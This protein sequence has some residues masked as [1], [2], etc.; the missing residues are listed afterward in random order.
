[1]LNKIHNCINACSS[2]VFNA[3]LSNRPVSS[4]KSA[5]ITCVIKQYKARTSSVGVINSHESA[6]S[7]KKP[8]THTLSI[9]SV[10]GEAKNAQRA[11]NR[12][13]SSPS[14][15][16]LEAARRATGAATPY[17]AQLLRNSQ[18]PRSARARA[19]AESR[20]LLAFTKKR[21]KKSGRACVYTRGRN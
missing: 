6:R 1:M 14:G 17:S 8:R 9:L 16:I 20:A 13:F 5:S 7:R 4:P 21:R 11:H 19:A 12:P 15:E 10:S 18:I 2:D 3:H